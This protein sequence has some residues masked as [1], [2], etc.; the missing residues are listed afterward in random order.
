MKRGFIYRSTAELT[1][2]MR[3]TWRVGPARMRCGTQGHVA[4]LARPTKG[5]CHG[6]VAG[7]HAS[8]RESP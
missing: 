3:L 5:R 6:H 2:R 7:G 4:E 1:W 8:P